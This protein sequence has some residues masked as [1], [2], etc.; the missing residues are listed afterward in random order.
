MYCANKYIELDA[1]AQRSKAKS[2][3]FIMAGSSHR[4]SPSFVVHFK[5]ARVRPYER[6]RA[7]AFTFRELHR[8]IVYTPPAM[9]T[10]AGVMFAELNYHL[11]TRSV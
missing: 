7:R 1:A 9:L 8:N 6:V 4:E 2:E 10:L 11:P 5:C 3:N